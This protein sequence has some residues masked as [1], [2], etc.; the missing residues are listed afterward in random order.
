MSFTQVRQLVSSFLPKAKYLQLQSEISRRIAADPLHFLDGTSVP[1]HAKFKIFKHALISIYPKRNEDAEYA[2]ALHLIRVLLDALSAKISTVTVP[3]TD[4]ISKTKVV[5][6]VKSKKSK[7]KPK[8][9]VVT[10]VSTQKAESEPSPVVEMDTIID[11]H[12]TVEPAS[13][14]SF[15][16][17][18]PEHMELPSTPCESISENLQHE[19][20]VNDDSVVVVKS[21]KRSRASKKRSGSAV[22]GTPENNQFAKRVLVQ[23]PRHDPGTDIG[24]E[25]AWCLIWR[26]TA[27]MVYHKDVESL[28]ECAPSIFNIKCRAKKVVECSNCIEV[29]LSCPLTPCEAYQCKNALHPTGVNL[30]KVAEFDLQYAHDSGIIKFMVP[31]MHKREL[32]PSFI[33][34]MTHDLKAKKHKAESF[35]RGSI[36]GCVDAYMK[37]HSR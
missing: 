11:S 21:S 34:V 5:K 20:P 19:Q 31:L 37:Q 18:A 3:H 7:A 33:Y 14:Q 6:D 25:E 8:I 22:P 12:H 2:S 10:T 17:P 4:E 32:F 36:R 23:D 28:L 29:I 9:K 13:E 24:D 30:H 27:E 15:T 26:R 1:D 35:I 16:P